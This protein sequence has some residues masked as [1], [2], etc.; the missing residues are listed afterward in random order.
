MKH[1][2]KHDMEST[3]PTPFHRAISTYKSSLIRMGT[4]YSA[5]AIAYEIVF[6]LISWGLWILLELTVGW[7]RSSFD[8]LPLD[9]EAIA[10]NPV[11]IETAASGL[12]F[13]V[14][15]MGLILLAFAVAFSLLYCFFNALI[16][17]RLNAQTPS[18]PWIRRWMKATGPFALF[19]LAL[20]AVTAFVFKQEWYFLTV[21]IWFFAALLGMTIL[22]IALSINTSISGWK[23]IKESPAILLAHYKTN[24]KTIIWCLFLWLITYIP[25]TFLLGLITDM[26]R[27]EILVP[28]LVITTVWL[29]KYLVLCANL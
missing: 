4:L 12:R 27:T 19:W 3:P 20:F 24:Y 10:Q 2:M 23:A 7:Q 28:Y 14:A 29:R 15:K 16:W 25:L 22:H 6:V 18:A 1:F 21:P 17:A 13:F 26:T 8:A 11:L 5:Y 9:R